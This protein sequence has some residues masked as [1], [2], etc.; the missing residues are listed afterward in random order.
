MQEIYGGVYLYN[1]IHQQR[2]P[3]DKVY[4]E[5]VM[6]RGLGVIEVEIKGE[7]L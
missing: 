4:V 6:E 2:R 1:Y 5:Y 7:G 3:G